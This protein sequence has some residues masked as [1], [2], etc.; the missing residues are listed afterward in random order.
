V[1]LGKAGSL[2]CAG[3]DTKAR[4]ATLNGLVEALRWRRKQLG[5]SQRELA[6][7]VGCHENTI[8]AIENQRV[9]LSLEDFD[10]ICQALDWQPWRVLRLIERHLK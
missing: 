7:K 5:L 9:R 4:G 6:D 10:G 1:T 2:A 3:D 8:C